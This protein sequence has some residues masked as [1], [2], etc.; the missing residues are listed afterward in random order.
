[1]AMLTDL[2]RLIDQAEIC[3]LGKTVAER[4]RYYVRQL[5]KDYT[6]GNNRQKAGKMFSHL[7]LYSQVRWQDD[8][9]KPL[10]P[11]KY[12]NTKSE[13]FYRLLKENKGCPLSKARIQEILAGRKCGKSA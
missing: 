13:W 12:R 6:L 3:F 9:K 11:A 5:L 10:I 7:N 2:Y 1:M 4:R 8:Q